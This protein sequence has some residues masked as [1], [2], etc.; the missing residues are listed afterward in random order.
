MKYLFNHDSA[1]KGQLVQN[2]KFIETFL[3]KSCSRLAEG[4]SDHSGTCPDIQHSWCFR[5]IFHGF[6]CIIFGN[7]KNINGFS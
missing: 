1:K 3:D 5:V 2:V 6:E 4:H 7:L